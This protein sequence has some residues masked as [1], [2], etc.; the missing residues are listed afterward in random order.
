L[1]PAGDNVSE[2]GSTTK[3][4]KKFYTSDF[5]LYNHLY[6]PTDDTYDIGSSSKHWKDI[7][8]SGAVRA[9]LSGF[10][11][12]LLPNAT[13]TYDL[14]SDTKKWSNIFSN[15]ACKVGWLDVANFIVITDARVLQNVT[16]DVAI[17]TSGQFPLARM[18]RGA[19]GQ[20]I[21]GYGTGF[22]PMYA[23][24]PAAD[25]P[26]HSHA[27]SDI[28]SGVLDE[29]RCPNVYSGAIHFNGGIITN[30]VNCK[31]WQLADL[32]FLN[33]FIVTEAWFD[34]GLVFL[35]SQKKAIAFLDKD[36]NLEVAGKITENSMKLKKLNQ[37]RGF[38]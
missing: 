19:A 24:I 6:P 21:R 4:F 20:Y 37:E 34:E 28:I 27:A 22:D 32:V 18:P 7:Y 35:N 29:A 16:A 15:G 25:L 2:L 13:G 23:T 14:G 8:L 3:T 12:H 1:W 10:A 30:S 26:A 17:I 9:L 33:K 36:G 31:N 11:I 38:A 5:A